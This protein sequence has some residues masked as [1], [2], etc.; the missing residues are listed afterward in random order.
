MLEQET[1]RRLMLAY[2]SGP[3][4]AKDFKDD[5]KRIVLIARLIDRWLSNSDTNLRLMVNHVVII[6]NVFGETGIYAIYEYISNFPECIAPLKSV[7]Y[8]MGR[9]DQPSM[10]DVD[11]FEALEELD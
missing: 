9:I 4:V 6:E 11:L 8:F 1:M 2:D 5:A 7:L 3:F 10:Y